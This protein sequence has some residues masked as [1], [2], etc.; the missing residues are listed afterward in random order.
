MLKKGKQIAFGDT[1]TL[2]NLYQQYL[3]KEIT[4]F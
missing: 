4:L 2:C 3:D 1:N